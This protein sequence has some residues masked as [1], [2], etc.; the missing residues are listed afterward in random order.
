MPPLRKKGFVA[1][2]IT[3]GLV[4]AFLLGPRAGFEDRWVEPSL[5][6]DLDSYLAQAEARVPALRPGDGKSIEW[7][8]PASP[9]VTP[10]SLVYLHGFSADRHE[11]EPLVTDLARE[12]GANVFFTRLRGHGRDAAAMG[13]ATVESWLDDVAEAVAIGARLGGRVVLMGTSTGGT[14]ALW[15]AAREE[16][17]DRLGSVVLISPN[18]GVRDPAARVLLWP[19][20]GVIGRWMVGPERCFQAKNADQ[21]RHWTTCYP[22]GALLP[23]M[24]LVDRVQSLPEGA[25]R[26]PTLV[27]YSRGDEVV[28]PQMTESLMP[29]LAEGPLELRAVEGSSD[30]EQ[31]VIAGAIMSPETTDELRRLILEF[32]DR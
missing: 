29:R 28:D 31:H 27:L 13:E 9:S 23:M 18:L 22:T 26:A 7:L 10:L 11:V 15:A 3:A 32:L 6:P 19:W 16:V 8:D 25:L 4:S 2:G 30:P 21:E 20:G 24:A 17:A 12:L 14:L 1:A 5:R